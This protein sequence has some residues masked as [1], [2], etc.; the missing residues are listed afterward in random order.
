MADKNKHVRAIVVGAGAGGGVIAKQLA[1]GG[2]ST[3]LFE[4]GQWPR[5]DKHI[6]DELISQRTQVLASAFGPD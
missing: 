6:N 4:R 5:Y 3:V 2:M 1:T